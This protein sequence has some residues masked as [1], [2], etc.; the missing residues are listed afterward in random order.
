MTCAPKP[1]AIC[2]PSLCPMRLKPLLGAITHAS[3]AGRP[4]PFRKYSKTVGFFG[5][6]S[7]KLSNRSYIRQSPDSQCHIMAKNSVIHYL[8]EERR[9]RNQFIHQMRNIF[10][11]FRCEGLFIARSAAKGNHDRLLLS[12]PGGSPQWSKTEQ[13]TACTSH[14]GRTQKCAPGKCPLLRDLL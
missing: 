14:C 1:G 6:T 4:S 9:L 12:R 10:L 2:P 7:A 5:A 11:S 8:R 3:F 13:P